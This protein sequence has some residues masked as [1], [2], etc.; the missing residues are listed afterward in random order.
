[1][2]A[3][4][5]IAASCW[6]LPGGRGQD[7]ALPATDDDLQAIPAHPLQ[8]ND[9]VQPVVAL[10]IAQIEAAGGAGQNGVTQV[11]ADRLSD[12]LQAQVAGGQ[13][14][15]L[16]VGEHHVHRP[17]QGQ[18][19][20][21]FCG[22]HQVHGGEGHAHQHIAIVVDRH[23]EAELA[24]ARD[25]S[26]Q[27][28]A[29]GKLLGAHRVAEVAAVGHV[30]LLRAGLG[31]AL[32]VALK[33]GHTD[34]AV[35][36]CGRC[37][38]AQE[39]KAEI[40]QV[41]AAHRGACGHGGQDLPHALDELLL[42]GRRQHAHRLDFLAPALHRFVGG[43]GVADH[44]HGQARQDGDDHQQEQQAADSR[45]LTQSIAPVG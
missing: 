7:I 31:Q 40:A 24:F 26:H 29:Q 41:V 34:V 14:R 21:A 20:Q 15:A 18:R 2:S 45:L 13:Q 35:A 3:A 38:V 1:M 12:G 8:R 32:D 44:Q 10:R 28:F 19:L 37:H 11:L 42:V 6:R 33:V 5:D 30:D 23:A 22:G 4:S 16:G 43:L 36:R 17:G 27:V 9:F 25:A 39:F